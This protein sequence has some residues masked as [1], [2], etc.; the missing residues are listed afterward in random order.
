M[1]A[2]VNL[3]TLIIEPEERTVTC[4]YRLLLPLV[5]AITSLEAGLIFNDKEDRE[6]KEAING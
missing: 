4:V 5:P 6:R 3:D 2:K 1:P